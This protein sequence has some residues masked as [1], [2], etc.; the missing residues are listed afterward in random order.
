MTFGENVFWWLLVG[1]G[2]SLSALFSGVETGTYA[3]NRVRLH[4]RAHQNQRNAVLLSKM[5]RNP[6]VLLGTLLIGNNVA[7]YMGTAGL[8]VLT[9]HWGLTDLQ[10][11]L[12]NVAIV[13]P[14][15]FVF[16]ETI[17]K[18]L[19]NANS[20]RLVYPLAV[21][22]WIARWLFTIPLLL[23]TVQACS[24][25]GMKMLGLSQAPVSYRPRTQM[26]VLVKEGV[27]YGLLSDEQSAIVERVLNLAS[28]T[29]DDEMTPWSDVITIDV[30]SS[31]ND[32]REVANRTSVSKYPVTTD[33]KVTGVLNV[34]GMLRHDPASCPP[35]RDLTENVIRM[36]ADTPAREA[37]AKLQQASIPLAVVES[38]SG[39]PLGVVTLKDL[40]EPITGE[41]ASW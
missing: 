25:L 33:G 14:M 7:N 6:T 3:L 26:G 27:G 39:A 23:P 28:R 15:L 2:L 19:F 20:D 10:V 41:L 40:V 22:L 38:P 9:Q 4:L 24:A 12:L 18:D 21:P 32:V 8:T 35:I 5:M 34:Y 1:V 29:V 16:G 30:A 36:P 13:T 31:P 17:P 37:L 11:V